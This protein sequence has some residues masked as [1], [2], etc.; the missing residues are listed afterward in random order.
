MQSIAF[1]QK[2]NAPHSG[3]SVFTH[4][5][6]APYERAARE[7]LALICAVRAGAGESGGVRAVTYRLKTPASI[8]G[9]LAKRG[10]PASDAQARA[11]YDIAG[12]RVVLSDV[13]TVYRF[14]RMLLASPDVELI[15]V[16]D[17]IASPKPGGY[18]SLHLVL[19]LG[20]G[21]PVEIQLRTT[22]M[23][24]WARLTHDACYK[25][26]GRRKARDFAPEPS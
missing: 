17:Y 19:R 15:R 13:E 14:A 9:K 4:A 25:P 24:Q 22:P 12:L 2:K 6:Y 16:R 3:E 23:D 10:L 18:Q 21:V 5:F 7:A 1:A 26:A 20:G 11:L 8:R